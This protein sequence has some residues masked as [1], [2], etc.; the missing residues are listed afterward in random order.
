M[1]I[2]KQIITVEGFSEFKLKEKGSIFHG[3]SFNVLND[4][5]AFEFLNSFRKKYYDATHHCYAYKLKNEKI[6][7]SDD[8]EPNGTAGIRILQAIEH[9][10]LIDTLVI[11]VRYYGG[12][13]LGTGPLGKAYFETS[14]KSLESAKK[15]ILNPFIKII[16]KAD[17]ETISYI[18]RLIENEKGIIINST[19]GD[20][21]N[22]EI[23]IPPSSIK[24]FSKEINNIS[25][26]KIEIQKSDKV[27][28]FNY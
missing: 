9:F 8:G 3:F 13:K 5:T 24:Y 22:F 10:N 26:G 20:A 23:L 16:F 28:Y 15:L 1:S 7:Y 14:L 19:Y 4:E 27:E 6:K 25:K 21:V 18:H 12:T 17:Y 11:V 2:E